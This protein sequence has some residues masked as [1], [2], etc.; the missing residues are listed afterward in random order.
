MS[1]DVSPF[2]MGKSFLFVDEV[3]AFCVLSVYL[4]KEQLRKICLFLKVLILV[5][6]VMFYLFF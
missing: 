4:F 3:K 2:F 5:F 1:Y 6:R